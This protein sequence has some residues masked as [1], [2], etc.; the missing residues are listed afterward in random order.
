MSD[1]RED[2]ASEIWFGEAR[3]LRSTASS[4]ER[5]NKDMTVGVTSKEWI[6]LVN[7]RDLRVSASD[8]RM[9]RQ[10]TCSGKE[11]A[12]SSINA[13]SSPLCKKD[14]QTAWL[15]GS[16]GNRARERRMGKRN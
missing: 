15:K 1:T 2:G 16:R 3:G 14:Y 12:R 5:I 13:L 8:S 10:D 11:N 9:G 4:D 7:R 6:E